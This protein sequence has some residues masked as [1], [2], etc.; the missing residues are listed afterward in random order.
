[1]YPSIDTL[2]IHSLYVN[3]P[4]M[5]SYIQRGID[6]LHE[7]A[8]SA[9][10][11]PVAAD[12][13]GLMEA[14]REQRDSYELW[15]TNCLTG[16]STIINL[17]PDEDAPKY[18][19][20]LGVIIRNIYIPNGTQDAILMSQFQLRLSIDPNTNCRDVLVGHHVA[21]HTQLHQSIGAYDDYITVIHRGRAAKRH[22]P[23]A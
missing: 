2:P 16:L 5:V 20:L 3:Y 13:T 17:V 12:V 1:M 11:N 23:A 7:V 18:L 10:A 8:T 21:A 14:T 6:R 22:F 4:N 9:T 15:R 19:Q